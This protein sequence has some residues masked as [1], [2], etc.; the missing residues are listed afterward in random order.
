LAASPANLPLP[1]GFK[2]ALSQAEVDFVIPD[3]A[4]DI[5]VCIDPFLLYKSRDESLR[6]LHEGLLAV[7]RHA[8]SLYEASDRK[9]LDR[10]IDF[11]E[12]NAIGFG[13]TRGGIHGSGLGW[14]L[15]QL[16]VDL[17]QSSEEVRA[18]GLRH[19]EELQLLS[20]GVGPDRVSD[21]TAGVLKAALID[22]TQRQAHLWRIPI[23]AAVPV[24]HYLDLADM[25][26][27]DGYFD[28]PVNPLNGQGLLLVPRRIV[29]LLPWI[30]YQ[31][32]YSNEARVFLPPAPRLP[33]YPG[34]NKAKSLEIAKAELV[35]KL[36]QAPGVLE[37]YVSRKERD[38]AKAGPL[39]PD[40]EAEAELQKTADD[41]L[42][43]LKAMPTG[44]VASAD[45]QR[46]VYEILNFL[47][48]PEL[49]GGEFEVSTYMGT[50]RRDLIYWNEA[51][52]SFWK[53]VRETYNSPLLMFECKN[54]AALEIDHINQTAAYLGARLGMLGIIATRSATSDAVMRKIYSIY[55]D[56]PALPRKV[57]LVFSDADMDAMLAIRAAG[58]SP[59]PYAQ[60]LYRQLRSKVQ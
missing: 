51:E 6:L 42:G 14:H 40:A 24:A 49:T 29:R 16:V 3:L 21:I 28:L 33:R 52:H 4:V 30:N 47:F 9:S 55:N 31:D 36:R 10:L 58:A 50:E 17:L 7:F 37:Q 2:L 44:A 26:W 25:E 11:P 35:Q 46:L 1:A 48:E 41:L 43:R 38:A 23:T 15:N 19:V 12:V 8:F 45:Y 5:P 32:F 56:S 57:I 53:Y 27:R 59:V 18:R 54:T 22:Y 60:N 34:M 20:V 13:Y 39:L